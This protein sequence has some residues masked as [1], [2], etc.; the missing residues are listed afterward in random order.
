MS[1]KK[2]VTYMDS[3][4]GYD[5]RHRCQDILLLRCPVIVCGV[6]ASVVYGAV[7]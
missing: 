4:R 2:T 1:R 5:P 7:Y 6:S 3:S